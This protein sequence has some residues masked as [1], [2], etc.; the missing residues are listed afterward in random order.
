MLLVALYGQPPEAYYDALQWIVGGSCFLLA[1]VAW[2]TRRAF[3]P[4]CLVLLLLASV[5]MMAETMHRHEWDVF[6]GFTIFF[7]SLVCVLVL[8]TRRP[9]KTGTGKDSGGS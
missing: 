9:E 8:V 3:A 4:L 6:A 7:L 5:Q 1:I 2:Q